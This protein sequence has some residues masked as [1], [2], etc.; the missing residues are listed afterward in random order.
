MKYKENT[1]EAVGLLKQLVAIPSLSRNEINAANLIEDFLKSKG[2]ITNRKGNNVWTLSEDFDKN[3][4]TILLDAHIDT[5]KPVNGWVHDP[6]TPEETEDG[7]IYG[8]G[9]NDDGGSLVSLMQV[10]LIDRITRSQQTDYNLIFLASCEEEVSGQNGI[11]CVI[12]EL[13]EIDFCVVGEPTNMQPAIAEKGLMV[14][15]VIAHGK[16]GHAARNEGVNAIYKAIDDINWVRNYC[17]EKQTDFLGPVKMTVTIVNA[18]SLHNVIPDEC[19]F[20]IDVR[21]NECYSNQEIL[22]VITENLNSDVKARSTRLNSSR[23]DENH[24]FVVRAA[25]LGLKPFGSP[26][27]SN[28]ALMPFPSV[29]IGPGDSARSHTADEFIKVAEI[30]DAI[31]KYCKLILNK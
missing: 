26:T 20:T 8:L 1:L 28:Q 18:G 16:A 10:F 5:V 21:S 15:D 17:F 14:I 31:D 7:V 3:K 24:P 27:L 2:C 6:F 19:K 23:L 11:E 9:T 25:A 12:P 4:T 22:D 30:D 29:K 13:P